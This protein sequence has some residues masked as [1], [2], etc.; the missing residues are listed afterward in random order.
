MPQP[1]PAD[2]TI[3]AIGSRADYFG[4]VI[5]QKKKQTTSRLTLQY[6][7]LKASNLVPRTNDHYLH[8]PV[9]Q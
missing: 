4:S 6:S 9:L 3:L 8:I 1:L 7:D 2:S 5:K